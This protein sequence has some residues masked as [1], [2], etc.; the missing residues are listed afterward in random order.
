LKMDREDCLHYVDPPYLIST[1]KRGNGTSPEHRYRH[2]MNDVDHEKLA[3]VLRGLKGMVIVSGY[4]SPLYDRLYAGWHGLEW[5]SGQFCNA[6][7]LSGS[8]TRTECI[9]MNDAAFARCPILRLF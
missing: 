3:E 7:N 2:E 4:P 1:R 5:T 8:R 9:W 6:S